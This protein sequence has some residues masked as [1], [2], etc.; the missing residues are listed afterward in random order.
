MIVNKRIRYCEPL[1][2]LLCLTVFGIV[3]LP[4]INR[5]RV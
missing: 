1:C 5:E 4:V 3:I 2:A